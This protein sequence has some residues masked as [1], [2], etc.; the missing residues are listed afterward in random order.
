MTTRRSFITLVG[1]AAAAAWQLAAR[2]QQPDGMRRIGVLANTAANNPVGQGR[3]A[4]FQ[5]A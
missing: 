1:G 2:A 3:I 4:A 5:L